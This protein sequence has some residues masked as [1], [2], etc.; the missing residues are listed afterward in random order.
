M[1]KSLLILGAGGHGRVVA[2]TAEAAGWSDVAFLDDDLT[3]AQGLAWP[4]LGPLAELVHHAPSF[5]DV[6]VAIADAQCRQTL[7]AKVEA[8]HLS[9]ATVVSPAAAVSRR[10]SIEP[11]CMVLAGAVVQTDAKLEVGCI[12]NTGASVD[13]DCLLERYVHVAPGSHLAGGVKV[14][15]G[16]WIGM[17]ATVNEHLVIGCSCTVGAGAAVVNH[18]GDGVTVVGVPARP[19]Q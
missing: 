2:D 11:G 12:V 1:S 14:G 4:V 16:S 5:D 10:S 17:G 19:V 3:S 6:I 15:T 9:L 7:I 8:E 13:H 18:V